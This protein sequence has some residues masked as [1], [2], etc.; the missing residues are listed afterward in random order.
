MAAIIGI[1]AES[2]DGA[3]SQNEQK[4]VLPVRKAF[5]KKGDTLDDVLDL[6]AQGVELLFAMEKGQFFEMSDEDVMKLGHE[7][8]KSYHVSKSLNEAHE[9]EMDGFSS[10]FS[11][12]ELRDQ[13]AK[14]LA[15]HRDIPG[16]SDALRQLTAYAGRGFKGRF[17]RV[18][19]IGYWQRKGFEVVKADSKTGNPLDESAFVDA[20]VH[21]GHFATRTSGA[22]DELVYMRETVENNKKRRKE[23]NESAAKFTE[24]VKHSGRDQGIVDMRDRENGPQFKE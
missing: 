1:N 13:R 8:R 5:V 9:P 20:P 14:T 6:D 19:K 18:D 24:K 16:A 7:N 15:Q 3:P 23:L 22:T 4:D 17:C 10:H 2:T 11:V 21:E 12:G